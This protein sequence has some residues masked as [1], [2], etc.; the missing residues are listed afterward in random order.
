MSRYGIEG[1]H[2][3]EHQDEA[4]RA[5]RAAGETYGKGIPAFAEHDRDGKKDA[6]QGFTSDEACGEEDAAWP[7]STLSPP[8][9]GDPSGGPGDQPAREDG[10]TQLKGQV[11]THGDRQ[12][13]RAE[14]AAAAVRGPR[15]GRRS[16][17]RSPSR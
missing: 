13:G 5:E 8:S 3:G 1:E 9:A 11:D 4:G 16:R 17:P 7:L 15:R 10:D 2:H 6:E 12:D 14:A